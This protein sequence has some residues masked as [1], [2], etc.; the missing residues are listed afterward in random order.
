MKQ[1]FKIYIH[2]ILILSIIACVPTAQKRLTTSSLGDP[3]AKV[4]PSSPTYNYSTMFIDD[5]NIQTTNIYNMD[6]FTSSFK[7]K[8]YSINS[9]LKQTVGSA[10]D[11]S[12]NY[13]C[14]IIPF[15]NTP[16]KEGLALAARPVRDYNV[17]TN[18]EDYY[19]L[20]EPNNSSINSQF[21]NFSS[22][23]NIG[24]LKTAA[25]GLC[26]SCT[27]TQLK[28]GLIYFTLNKIKQDPAVA[29][30]QFGNSK[31]S[32]QIKKI[33]NTPVSVNCTSSATC[34]S[35]GSDCCLNGS[36]VKDKTLKSSLNPIS[37]DPAFLTAKNDIALFPNHI[38]NYPQFYNICPS[39]VRIP[40]TV[41]PP[42]V[43]NTS[44]V[45]FNELQEIYNCINTTDGESSICTIKELNSQTGVTYFTK[46]DDLNYNNTY[47][48]QQQ[49]RKESIVEVL[50]GDSLIYLQD[51]AI[52]STDINDGVAFNIG[53]END[54]LFSSQSFILTH[55]LS[56]NS[57]NSDLKI[58]YKVNGS[59]KKINSQ[60]AQCSKYYI[61]GQNGILKNNV[62]VA[63]VQDHFPSSNDFKLPFYTD[64]T[65]PLKVYVDDILSYQGSDWNLI[66][67]SPSIIQFTGITQQIMDSQK[68]RIDYYVNLTSYPNL[69]VAKE[70]AMTSLQSKCNCVGADCNLTPTL[71]N[72]K[73]VDYQCKYPPKEKIIATPLLQTVYLSSK[74][75]PLRYYDLNGAYHKDVNST[76][77]SQE[78]KHFSYDKNNLLKPNN[79]N[80]YIGWHEIYGTIDSNNPTSAKP[81]KEIPVTKNKSYDIYVDYGSFSSCYNCGTDYYSNLASIFP[82]NFLHKGG[83][84]SPKDEL[85]VDPFSTKVLRSDNLNFGRS[86]FVP[87]SMI[88]WTHSA[89][90][91][92][93]N[94]SDQRLKRLSAQHFLFANGYNK[95]WFGFDYGS[96]IGSFD[97]I[98]WFSIGNQRRITAKTNK[99][100]IAVNTYFTDL[101]ADSGYTVTVQET[102]VNL[103][104]T[105]IPTDDFNSD[106]AECQSY[107][108][109]NN[110]SDCASKLGWEYSCENVGQLYSNWP[111]TDVNGF[112][113]PNT[114]Q[115]VNLY[116]LFNAQA[117]GNKRCVYRGKGAV[118]NQNYTNVSA[119]NSYNNSN[120]PGLQMCSNNTHCELLNNG[121]PNAKFNN[122]IARYGKSVKYQNISP[123]VAI[124]NANTFGKGIRLIGNPFNYNG[125]DTPP[126]QVFPSLNANKVRAMCVPGRN[127]Y[128]SDLL[129]S[130]Y[131]TPFSTELGDQTN[132]MGV[133]HNGT[134]SASF[135]NSCPTFDSTGN[136]IGKNS[137]YNQLT[138]SDPKITNLAATQNLS[139]KSLEI[140]ENMSN[141]SLTKDFNLQQI[142]APTHGKNRCLRAPGST[143]HTDMDCGP[144]MFVSSRISNIDSNNSAN[145]A[146]L[147][148]FEI[149]FWQE[150][151]VC[152]QEK[153]VG[154]LGFDPAQ[155]R[156]CR[157]SNTILS[158]A[159]NELNGVKK[160][161]SNIAGVNTPLSDKNRYSRHATTLD[162]RKGISLTTSYPDL[163]VSKK[164]Q[165]GTLGTTCSSITDI[166]NQ[167]NTLSET[168]SRTCCTGHWVRNF[169]QQNGG[170]HLWEASKM[171]VIPKKSFQCMNWIPSAS[172]T[173]GTFTCSD[174]NDPSC[175][176]AYTPLPLRT[177]LFDWI[178]TLELIGI[179]QITIAKPDS[180]T[181]D[182]LCK[183]D[184]QNLFPSSN[185]LNLTL[186]ET[187]LESSIAEYQD[188]VTG[189][190]YLSS[191]DSSNLSTKI[192]PIFS[193]DQL[194]C[195]LPL[196]STVP[197]G[198]P[199]SAC[200]SGY[201][202]PSNNRCKLKD[203]TNLT[204]FFNKYVSSATKGL[205]TNLFDERT[206][207]LKD[208]NMVAKLAC[209]LSACDSGILSKGIAF[210]NQIVP[211]TA[212]NQTIKRFVDGSGVDDAN[213]AAIS[214]LYDDGLKWENDYY[215]IPATNNLQQISSKVV[216]CQ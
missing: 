172:P 100:F 206:G 209:Q 139:T 130:N 198:S 82:G 211:G 21:C 85:T 57:L 191:T 98:T 35:G 183:V 37:T 184:P 101:M 165:C 1:F 39:N 122:K 72:G 56:T 71:L 54:D 170:G 33:G 15:L 152:S 60:L 75:I 199:D 36:C 187:V 7:I 69:M 116:Q 74:T 16:G 70:L 50:H 119:S 80:N 49:I 178:N 20:V 12:E 194:S 215:C 124:S 76:T 106:G 90:F 180:T 135:Y 168:A 96:V 125:T 196:N 41:T 174:L 201:K 78:G 6:I 27:F 131:M 149:Q 169:H 92:P 109:C 202:N 153:S 108:T 175:L 207:Y 47:Y 31:I 181:P 167:F 58:K 42:P 5:G 62:T 13:K 179:P 89:A 188:S 67:S 142:T 32:V 65:K 29:F 148:Q 157:E 93:A 59:C 159:T 11:N 185:T 133:T 176:F 123:D 117:G 214:K 213:T 155:N 44:T 2:L 87:L 99:L 204:V 38:I 22:V 189:T 156:C 200:C 192:K 30:N 114:S 163:N 129:S 4:A 134:L 40:A 173:P 18:I 140:L 45:R 55:Q 127:I 208:E 160:Y 147:N 111:S 171:Q 23:T 14:I 118:C 3:F 84:Y 83:G 162:L 182:L 143:C 203:F 132:G 158:V 9:Y 121:V 79:L 26:N 61:Q 95:D 145:Q 186:Q 164:D 126:L 34:V 212:T 141:T 190:K 68:V 46:A 107:Y 112:E 161:N 105:A 28:S 25:T 48:G 102:N 77:P 19:Y 151:M 103:N 97:G 113:K 52:P 88:P 193:P 154:E 138:L 81:A 91:D 144:S 66:T 210:S 197:N 136:Y 128:A 146:I 53:T 195:C 63:S 64:I 150:P 166:L 137:T 10:T 73:L 94:P 115:V 17:Q 120:S 8:S 86:C 177:V 24:N 216:T 205:S 104:T 43:D 51:E 110:D